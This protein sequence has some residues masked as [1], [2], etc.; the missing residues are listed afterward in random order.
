[1]GLLCINLLKQVRQLLGIRDGASCNLALSSPL[2][3]TC[4]GKLVSD[5]QRTG[6][7]RKGRIEEGRKALMKNQDR[8]HRSVSSK[9]NL[10]KVP[11]F[12]A[13]NDQEPNS[14]GEYTGAMLDADALPESFTVCSA[15]MVDA[16]TTEFFAADAVLL[17]NDAGG[18]WG[19]ISLTPC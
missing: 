8:Q 13:D 12:S 10:S 16:W 6:R 19:K 11:D 2:T 14:N 7:P 15:I 9:G 1:M 4:L 17:L 5:D 3:H 18:E